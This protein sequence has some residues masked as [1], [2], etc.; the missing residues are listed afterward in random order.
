[1]TQ[2]TPARGHPVATEPVPGTRTPRVARDEKRRRYLSPFWRHFLQMFAVMVAGAI[3]T[4]AVFLSVVGLKT[5]GEVTTVYPTQALLA[6]AGGMTAPMVAWMV[7]RGWGGGTP[8][9]WPRRW[10]SRCCRS[11]VCSGSG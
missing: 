6:M 3:G 10:C 11:S 7:Y 5:W 2:Q 8:W 9:R 4:G 1:M